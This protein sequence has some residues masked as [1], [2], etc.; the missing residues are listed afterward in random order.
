MKTLMRKRTPRGFRAGVTLVELMISSAIMAMI[1]V[2]VSAAVLSVVRHERNT[3]I[4]HSQIT[5]ARMVENNV[6]RILRHANRNYITYPGAGADGFSHTVRFRANQTAP[7][8]EISFDPDAHQLFF[9]P[10][11][12][13]AGGERLLGGVGSRGAEMCDLVDV[14]FRPSI[15]AI[16]GNP[17]AGMIQVRITTSDGGRIRRREMDSG[18]PI[19]VEKWLAIQVRGDET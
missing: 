4:E 2:G 13:T 12:A 7:F 19:V 1:M 10:D 11:R 8:Q 9:D 14:T 17:E 15:N 6:Q 16:D 18:D 5:Q 3:L